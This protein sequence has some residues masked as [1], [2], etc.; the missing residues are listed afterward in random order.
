[1]TRA[2]FEYLLRKHATEASQGCPALRGKR[3]APH[4]LRHYVPLL[5]MSCNVKDPFYMLG[6]CRLSHAEPD[7]NTRHSFPGYRLLRKVSSWSPG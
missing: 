4:V 7:P 3:V 5:T 6:N 1:M 2:G